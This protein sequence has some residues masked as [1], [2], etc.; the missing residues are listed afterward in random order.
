MK[1][2]PL[3]KYSQPL[4]PKD[5]DFTENLKS[6]PILSKKAIIV[7][8]TTML[9]GCKSVERDRPAT[10]KVEHIIY[11]K[12]NP[13]V[14]QESLGQ[15]C[16]PLFEHGE[17][18][19]ATGCVVTASPVF[20]SEE[21]AQNII[22]ETFKKY[23]IEFDQKN[24][25]EK[26]LNAEVIDDYPDLNTTAERAFPEMKPIIIDLFSTKN[27]LGIIFVS[28]EDLDYFKKVRKNIIIRSSSESFDTKGMAESIISSIYYKGKNTYGVFYDPLESDD[29]DESYEN[30]GSNF[31]YSL[32][33]ELIYTGSDYSN[34]IDS[35]I[36]EKTKQVN[37]LRKSGNEAEKMKELKEEI[38]ILLDKQ[39]DYYKFREY[40]WKKDSILDDSLSEKYDSEIRARSYKLIQAQ[41][42]D[43]ITWLKEKKIIEK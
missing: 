39:T 18:R 2:R 40:V 31:A 34:M 15:V 21:D 32:F 8:I 6:Y 11:E 1:I 19:G 37:V 23:G 22:I 36:N 3:K 28:R 43:F 16:A 27:K 9:F 41:V 38:R 25:K 24:R 26:G 13:E 30:K 7:A 33:E 17:G 20:V 29:L 4:Y 12:R 35:E 14:S 10:D 5:T 42:N